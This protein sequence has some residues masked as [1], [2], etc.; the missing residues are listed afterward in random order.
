MTDWKLNSKFEGTKVSCQFI[1][2]LIDT[3]IIA[4]NINS[5]NIIIGGFSMGGAMAIYCGLNYDQKL[6][7]IICLSGYS[8][9]LKIKKYININNKNTNILM[10]HGRNDDKVPYK[11]GQLTYNILKQY[12]CNI[13]FKSEN[14]Q[15]NVSDT[16]MNFVHQYIQQILYKKTGSC[17]LLM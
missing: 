8:P 4:H 12:G 10:Y 1:H 9:S 17:C 7:G 16:E 15:H 3:E 13:I 2:R 11:Y 14:I 6:G 5:E